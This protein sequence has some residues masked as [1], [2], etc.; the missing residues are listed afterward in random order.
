MNGYP[1]LW[2]SISS[3][4][5]CL[6][7]SRL[8]QI[9]WLP[10][11]KQIIGWTSLIAGVGLFATGEFMTTVLSVLPTSAGMVLAGVGLYLV[12]DARNK[13]SLK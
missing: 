2:L 12:I 10:S 6:K 8:F 11:M 1:P 5:F 13:R 3:I 9:N 7:L 4:S